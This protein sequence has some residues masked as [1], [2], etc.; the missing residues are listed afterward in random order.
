MLYFCS[1]SCEN[2]GAA[3]APDEP[4]SEPRLEY[5]PV[6]SPTPEEKRAREHAHRVS[7]ANTQALHREMDALTSSEDDAGDIE[8]TQLEEEAEAEATSI[9]PAIASIVKP[10]ETILARVHLGRDDPEI[11]RKYVGTISVSAPNVELSGERG[12]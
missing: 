1:T 6:I 11:P 5:V 10:P 3:R 9:P 7:V 12:E 2:A 4:L 8:S